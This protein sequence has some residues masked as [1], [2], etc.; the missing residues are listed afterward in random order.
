M[1]PR[2]TAGDRCRGRAVR[3]LTALA[4]CVVLTTAAGGLMQRAWADPDPDYTGVGARWLDPAFSTES[5]LDRPEPGAR[6]AESPDV[7]RWLY[8]RYRLNCLTATDGPA[9]QFLWVRPEGSQS[10]QTYLASGL[11]QQL[12]RSQV[13]AAVSAFAASNRSGFR[14]TNPV[15]KGEDRT[16]RIITTPPSLA[17]GGTCQPAFQQ[18]TVPTAV[19]MRHPLQSRS[20]GDASKQGVMTYLE[21]HGF[22]QPNRRYFLFLD[23]TLLTPEQRE[24]AVPYRITWAQSINMQSR[25][26][27]WG[28]YGAG[29]VS[30]VDTSPGPE[31]FCNRGGMVGF[32]SVYDSPVPGAQRFTSMLDPATDGLAYTLAHE[33]GHTTCQDYLAP[34]FVPSTLH[35]SDDED[36][37]GDGGGSDQC[38]NP[39]VDEGRWLA[40][41][42]C[43]ADDYWGQ[44]G[45]TTK[46]PWSAVRWD[47]SNSEYLWGAPKSTTQTEDFSLAAVNFDCVNLG[48][49]WD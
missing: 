12:I 38:G 30:D 21:G 4:A 18:V 37:M 23:L 35:M 28:P 39:A 11:H 13:R 24:A 49:C 29:R 34:H 15:Q 40:R 16:P 32:I 17:T 20:H 42:D 43:A 48:A 7:C 44:T 41:F 31:N 27:L 3:A 14:P 10:Q 25:G 45:L 33:L 26:V 2:S 36:L 9:Y 46:A 22:D 47:S 8:N 5:W 1:T 6:C 19:L